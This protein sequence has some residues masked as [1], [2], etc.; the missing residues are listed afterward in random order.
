M[1]HFRRYTYTPSLY[2]IP[3]L[4]CLHMNDLD[5]IICNN[6]KVGG[7]NCVYK[8]RHPILFIYYKLFTLLLEPTC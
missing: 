8:I 7:I 3:P 5:Q 4:T 2:K 6:Y 1:T